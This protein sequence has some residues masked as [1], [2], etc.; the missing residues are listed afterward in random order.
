MG[1]E[2]TFVALSDGPRP[3][4]GC[5][6]QGDVCHELDRRLLAAP[7]VQHGHAAVGPG[8]VSL[9]DAG[10]RSDERVL[11]DELVGYRV[12]SLVLAACPEQLLDP[13]GCIA[14]TLL[15]HRALVEVERRMSHP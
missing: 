15:L 8:L 11:V 13:G 2:V 3:T 9:S 14:V 5:R 6:T 4:L 10:R 1:S 7:D 12:S